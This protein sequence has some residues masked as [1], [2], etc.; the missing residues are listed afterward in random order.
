MIR[1]KGAKPSSRWQMTMVA[2]TAL[3]VGALGSGCAIEGGLGQA[4]AANDCKADEARCARAS[5]DRPIAVGGVVRPDL[6]FKLRGAGAPSMHYR[7][8][9]ETILRTENGR[10]EG[11]KDGM[12]AVLAVSDDG[13]V[14]D[15]FHVWVK[16][17]THVS[18]AGYRGA[19]DRV[20]PI[21]DRVELL[22][23]ESLRIRSEIDGE[24]QLLAGDIPQGWKVE[25]SAVALLDDGDPSRRRVVAVEPG[26]ARLT[27]E[28]GKVSTTMDVVVVTPS[29]AAKVATKESYR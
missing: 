14:L 12:T 18:L 15:F 28:V 20:E 8:A 25:G 16:S 24:G 22:P 21:A 11:L 10:I 19:S 6:S 26:K 17:P 9:D 4:V 7:A 1:H 13:Y 27:V 3:A 2:V 29:K 23:G 5:F